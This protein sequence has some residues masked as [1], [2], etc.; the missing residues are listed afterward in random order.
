MHSQ[1]SAERQKRAQILESEGNRQSAINVAEGRKQSQ[2][3]ASEGE[4]QERIN[5]A[6]GE[7]Q[8]IIAKATA[9]A[10]SIRQIAQAID[11]KGVPAVSMLVA[12]KYIGAF[13]KLAKEGT[14]VLLPASVGDVT[15]M[16]AQSLSIFKALDNKLPKAHDK[17]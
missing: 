16:V 11:E 2:I 9:S 3:L 14:T 15:A 6:Q 10:E 8:A 12:E 13:E 17:S 1:V 7:A 4:K 5:Q